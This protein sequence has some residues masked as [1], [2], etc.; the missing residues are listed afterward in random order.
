MAATERHEK[1]LS[2]GVLGVLA[3]IVVLVAFVVLHR[4]PE[5]RDTID[6]EPAPITQMF[7]APRQHNEGVE[8][9]FEKPVK[10]NAF[11]D[12]EGT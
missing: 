9:V 12:N 8:K 3:L 4:A 2:I 6:R 11:K 10:Q 1:I 5:V 7:H